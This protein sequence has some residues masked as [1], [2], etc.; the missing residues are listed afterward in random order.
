MYHGCIEL[1]FDRFLS[2]VTIRIQASVCDTHISQT[3]L[4]MKK[5]IEVP[6]EDT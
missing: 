6:G 4:I 1:E 5:A 2:E 3:T